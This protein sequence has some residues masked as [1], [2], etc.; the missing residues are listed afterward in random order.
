MFAATTS[1]VPTRVALSRRPARARPRRSGA[2]AYTEWM[3]DGVGCSGARS[4]DANLVI[5]KKLINNVIHCPLKPINLTS[6]CESHDGG[7]EMTCAKFELQGDNMFVINLAPEEPDGT[8][9]DM[10]VDGEIVPPLGKALLRPGAHVKIGD[11]IY[12]VNR[13]THAHA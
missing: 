6:L 11:E 8:V 7:F 9:E 10:I 12:Q 5:S 2:V 3:L 1:I 13:N 4:D